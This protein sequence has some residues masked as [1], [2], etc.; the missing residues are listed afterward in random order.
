MKR[1]ARWRKIFDF[2]HHFAPRF[3]LECSPMEELKIGMD[4][5]GRRV[6]NA[7][8]PEWGDGTVLRIEPAQVAGCCVQRLSIQF[9]VGHRVLV[10]PPARLVAA[11]PEPERR[12]GWLEGLG[13]TTMDDRLR[14]LP[15]NVTQVLGSPRERLAAVLPFFELTEQSDSLLNWARRQ[16]GVSDPLSHWTRD[17]L[18][19]AWQHFCGERDAH[20]RG[21]AALLKRKEGVTGLQDF[22]DRIPD[23]A[24]AAALAALRAPI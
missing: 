13:K 4:L 14:R 23:A 15:E 18:L 2:R 16:I 5:I 24:R 21:L 1:I 19:V 22:I 7:A 6:R 12:A 11:I 9:A 3:G 17:E 20:F 10:S 8:R